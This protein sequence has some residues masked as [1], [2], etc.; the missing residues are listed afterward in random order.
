MSPRKPLMPVQPQ[1]ARKSVRTPVLRN[2]SASSKRVRDSSLDESSPQPDREIQSQIPSNV[3]S[4]TSKAQTLENDVLPLRSNVSSGLTSPMMSPG[5]RALDTSLHEQARN[6]CPTTAYD[7]FSSQPHLKGHFYSAN[8]L[9][10]RGVWIG[11]LAPERQ[12]ESFRG[13]PSFH[14]LKVNYS[15]FSPPY[16]PI[17]QG[18]PRENRNAICRGCARDES[19]LIALSEVQFGKNG[20]V[21]VMPLDGD[22]DAGVFAIM[23]PQKSDRSLH[24]LQSFRPYELS[25]GGTGDKFVNNYMML[26]LR[27]PD[28]DAGT[29]ET[30]L[31]VLP[32]KER[33]DIVLKL[34]QLPTHDKRLSSTPRLS[35]LSDVD[36]TPLAPPVMSKAHVDDSDARID[37]PATRKRRKI[38]DSAANKSEPVRESPTGCSV[39]LT[40]PPPP[41]SPPRPQ[42]T[43]QRTPTPADDVKHHGSITPAPSRPPSQATSVASFSNVISLDLTDEQ[44]ARIC[45]IWTVVDDDIEYEFVHALVECKSFGGLLGILEEDAEAIPSAASMISRTNVWRLTYRLGNGP[46]KAVVL[47]K[48]TEVAFD[49]LQLTLAQASIWQENPNVKIDIELKSLSRS[50]PV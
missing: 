40:Q 8:Q 20:K 4:D 27:N 35:K 39:D 48:G 45:F 2:P 18:S 42:Q 5:L 37:E 50:D 34:K 38:S 9:F 32:P 12:N 19:A 10:Q 26:T 31:T 41:Q 47:R 16:P 14:L 7:C 1:R 29:L 15:K 24:G 46:N 33:A 21:V 30:V 36:A 49:R 25:N 43:P 13:M 11:Y 17:V 44:A 28:S 22:D 3:T 23:I 6:A